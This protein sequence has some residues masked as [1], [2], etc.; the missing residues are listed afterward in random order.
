MAKGAWGERRLSELDAEDRLAM[1]CEKAPTSDP[2]TS[3]LRA[4]FRVALPLFPSLYWHGAR[5]LK[6][7]RCNHIIIY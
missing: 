2:A 7:Q 3:A 5:L 1:A 4:A 6:G